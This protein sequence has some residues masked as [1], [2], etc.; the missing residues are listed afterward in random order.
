MVI[1]EKLSKRLW[2]MRAI[3]IFSVICAHCNMQVMENENPLFLYE[4]HIVSNFGTLGVGVFFFLSGFFFQPWNVK[5]V[6]KYI[7]TYIIPW[8]V[9]AMAVY[10]YVTLRKGTVNAIDYILFTLGYGSLYYFMTD[11]I[12]IQGIM[13]FLVRII[14]KSGWI[15]F[16]CTAVNLLVLYADMRGYSL[17]PTVYLNPC[18]FLSFF[19][20]GKWLRDSCIISKY[21]IWTETARKVLKCILILLSAVFLFSG[22]KLSYYMGPIEV[23]VETTFI[24]MLLVGNSERSEGQLL[25]R[26]GKRSFALYLW[27]IPLAGIISNIF[28][29]WTVMKYVFFLWPVIVL[30]LTLLILQSVLCVMKKLGIGRYCW[31]LGVK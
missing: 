17:T 15:Y 11:L 14:R 19:A 2:V 6:R 26:I 22:I 8:L 27:H 18:I 20:L 12:I 24:L 30:L 16:L 4:A 23:L 28:N 29:R 10:L 7:R 1:N 13:S 25:Q 31:L 9:S 21:R 5:N 3:A